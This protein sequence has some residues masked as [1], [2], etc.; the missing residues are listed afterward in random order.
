MCEIGKIL[1]QYA[2]NHL[3]SADLVASATKIQNFAVDIKK[4]LQEEG[5]WKLSENDISTHEL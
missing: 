4:L 5:K 1:V 3:A 2:I